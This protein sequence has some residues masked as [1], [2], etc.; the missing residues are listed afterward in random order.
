MRGLIDRRVTCRFDRN[1]TRLAVEE[2]IIESD[3]MR[4]T[5]HLTSQVSVGAPQPTGTRSFTAWIVATI[6][7]YI[8]S[9]CL[10]VCLSV[11]A[12]STFVPRVG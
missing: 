12:C 5:V 2:G 9:L 11:L 3:Y 8:L 1:T 10:S 7:M 4:T 6:H